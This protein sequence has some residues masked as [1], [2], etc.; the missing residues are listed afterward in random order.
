MLWYIVAFGSGPSWKGVALVTIFMFIP[1][2]WLYGKAS[3]INQAINERCVQYRDF[4]YVNGVTSIT[5]LAN[6][7]GQRAIVVK[8]EVKHHINS[9]LLPDLETVGDRILR[10]DIDVNS[11]HNSQFHKYTVQKETPSQVHCDHPSHSAASAKK[12]E[13]APKPKPKTVQC[14]GCGASITIMEGE[15]K[16][17]EYCENTLS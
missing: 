13:A 7:T 8:N 1:S 3:K 6:L 9:G 14:H 15:T 12:P 10:L 5:E 2:L 4:I 17:C 16:Q 11:S